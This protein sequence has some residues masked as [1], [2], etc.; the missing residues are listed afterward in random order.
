MAKTKKPKPMKVR[1]P[2]DPE[3][4]RRIRMVC[5]HLS[6]GLLLIGVCGAGYYYADRYVEERVANNSQPMIV[7]LKNRPPWMNDFLVEQIAA[8]ARPSG[9]HSAFDHN[10]LATTADDLSHNPWIRKVHSVRR[11]FTYKPGDTLEIDCEYRASGA[12]KVRSILLARR[13]NG[14]ASLG[15]IQRERC[16][17]HPVQP[18]WPHTH[19]SH[20]R[21]S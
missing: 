9:S 4:A 1:N 20:R 10:L 6:L 14:C 15:T 12:R 7:V 11:A 18:R 21:Y 17:Q 19:P 5:L 3:R 16:S 2:M 8:I 13:R